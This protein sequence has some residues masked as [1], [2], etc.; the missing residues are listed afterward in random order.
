MEKRRQFSQKDK[1][2]VLRSGQN[3]GIVKSA[4]LAG[5][6]YSTVYEWRGKLEVLGEEAFLAYRPKSRGRGVKKVTKEQ[7]KAVLDTFNGNVYNPHKM[8]SRE[9]IQKLRDDGWVLHHTKG[10]HYQ[11]KHPE[12]TGEVTVPHPKKDIAIGTLRNIFRQAG[13]DWR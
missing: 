10:D 9:I 1:L 7:E 5:V 3:I 11:F 2:K 8:N 12:K 6:H 13:W 4:Q